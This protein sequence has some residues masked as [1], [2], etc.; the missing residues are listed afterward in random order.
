MCNFFSFITKGDGVAIF[1]PAELRKQMP[2]TFSP[3][4]HTSIATYFLG[5]SI[6]DDTVNKYE[7]VDG[8]L[9]IDT[10]STK[11][12]S[13]LVENWIKE[14]SKTDEFIELRRAKQIE[15]PKVIPSHR[16][17]SPSYCI[18]YRPRLNVYKDAN[19][20]FNPET[21]EGF[22]YKWWKFVSKIKGKVVFNSYKYS[23]TTS[24]HQ[25]KMRSLL[26]QLGIKI[27]IEVECPKG[28]QD[29]E[30]GIRYY[31]NLNEILMEQI[32]NPRANL[33]KN[34]ERNKMIKEHR[35]KIKQL[36]QLIR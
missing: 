31:N 34:A 17:P 8:N 33:K 5:N 3:D 2:D 14:Y 26:R 29:L 15:T 7:F 24:K 9:V 21:C 1:F 6:S 4:S 35:E 19:V 28:L 23:V 36:K 30:S 25:Y 20:V 13:K 10:I 32:V 18:K 16:P 11:D 27:D 22:S 12:D